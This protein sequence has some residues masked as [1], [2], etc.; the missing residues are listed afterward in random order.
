M[1]SSPRLVAGAPAT[2]DV[3]KCQLKPVAASDY[4]T[5]PSAA[6]LDALKAAFPQGVCD[7][8]KPGVGQD[9]KLVTWA[10]FTD[11]GKWSALA[12]N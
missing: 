2:E 5:A 11:F 3:I 8:S 12:T 9:T 4:K 10:V 7:F 1:F 6:Q